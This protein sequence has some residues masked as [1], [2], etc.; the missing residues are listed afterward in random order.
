MKRN[1]IFMLAYIAFI[2]LCAWIKPIYDFPMWGRIVA[3]ITTASWAFAVSDCCSSISNIQ[4]DTYVTYFPLVDTAI[5]KI[6]QI[7]KHLL[8]RQSEQSDE[9]TI[10]IVD[11]CRKRCENILGV[12]TK[13]NKTSRILE[14]ASIA[15]TFFAFL[16]FLCT[17]A[18]EPVY[19]YFFIRQDG[20]TVLSFGMILFAQFLT[21]VGGNH[22]NNIKKE[23]TAVLNGWEALLDS[24]ETEENQDAD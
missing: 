18:F 2:F 23:F 8:K 10:E 14:I 1:N 15:M 7:K 11:S 20:L 9:P 24:Y 13:M 3:A 17:L 19:N 4:K 12:I 22:V 21:N 6:N 5:F 16:L